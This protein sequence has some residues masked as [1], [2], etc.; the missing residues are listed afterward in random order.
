MLLLRCPANSDYVVSIDYIVRDANKIK[1][2][3]FGDFEGPDAPAQNKQLIEFR[4][5]SPSGDLTFRG[6]VSGGYGGAGEAGAFF[7][8]PN[9]GNQKKVEQLAQLIAKGST[10]V[11]V[12]VHDYRNNRKTIET[13][14]PA[15]DPASDMVRD[16][17]NKTD[18]KSVNS[19]NCSY[20]YCLASGGTNQRNSQRSRSHQEHS[21]EVARDLESAR[22]E[23][24]RRTR[25]R[26]C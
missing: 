17:Q 22:Y 9:A 6:S 19:P 21:F 3:N 10:Q 24:A 5:I 23:N 18:E 12:I 15:I 2:F 13:A 8:T 14:F 11:I 25:R 16:C 26:R 4:A 20:L 1:S 7:F